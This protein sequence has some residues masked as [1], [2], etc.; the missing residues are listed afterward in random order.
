MS[1]RVRVEQIIQ[2]HRVDTVKIGGSDFDGIFRGKRLPAD[3][4][5]D[6]LEHGFAQGDVLF[7]WDIAEDLVPGLRF[8]NWDTGYADLRMVPDPA[9]FR[10]VPWE[11]RVAT[12]IC[13]FV[14]EGGEP[15]QV[16][17]RHVL[18]RVLERAEA[19]GYRAELA[20]ELEFRIWREDQRSLREKRWR[21]L[22]P[23]SPTTS[24]Y[25]LHR[26]T[27]DEFIVGRLRRQMDLHGVPI[28]GYNGEHGEGMYE[29]NIRH[30]PGL[31]AADRALL[32]RNGAKE[33]CTLEGLT[34]SFM[35][36]PFD[37]Q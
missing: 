8:T 11:E 16:A 33:L 27:G 21:D 35:A 24:C 2:E 29:M 5:L 28:E 34:A 37:D 22:T 14:T 20:V 9:T 10:L 15:V 3:V 26:A 36:K 32:F 18:R 31:E 23:L 17:P 4:F 12:V 6:G 30:A 25:S 13:D 19:L 7:G 1:E